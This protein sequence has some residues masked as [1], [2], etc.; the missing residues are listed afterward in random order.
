[1]KRLAAL[2]L[3]APSLLLPFSACGPKPSGPGSIGRGPG[4]DG[5]RAVQDSMTAVS[6]FDTVTVG[7]HELES[8]CLSIP[9]GF[10]EGASTSS[11]ARPSG[12]CH[13][14]AG[15]PDRV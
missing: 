2:P 9:T 13:E 14:P 8:R 12:C 3:R 1:M 5:L 15:A 11:L 10:E 4:I 6:F 7:V